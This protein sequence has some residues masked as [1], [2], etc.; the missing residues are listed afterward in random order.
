MRDADTGIKKAIFVILMAV[1]VSLAVL[2]NAHAANLDQFR[3]WGLFNSVS[4]SHIHAP[5]AW[6][7]SEGSKKIVVAVIDTGI[8]VNH[9]DLKENIL[10]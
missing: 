7:L 9:P 5:D 8:D 3:N 1:L 2:I 10:A 4:D 6:K